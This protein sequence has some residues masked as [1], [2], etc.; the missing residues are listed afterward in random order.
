MCDQEMQKP[1]ILVFDF[2]CSFVVVGCLF[3]CLFVCFC[4]CCCCCCCFLCVVFPQKWISASN[5]WLAAILSAILLSAAL[6]A[7]YA[8]HWSTGGSFWAL[9]A[10]NAFVWPPGCS[11]RSTHVVSLPTSPSS[12]GIEQGHMSQLSLGAKRQKLVQFCSCSHF[13]LLV[14]LGWEVVATV[15]LRC[16]TTSWAA[17]PLSRSCGIWESGDFFFLS[18]RNRAST[19]VAGNI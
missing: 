17:W 12:I 14:D 16:P 2:C 9:I 11:W 19:L 7:C 6:M 10:G 4:F 3:V 18:K 13:T 8:T 15:M 1:T 5:S